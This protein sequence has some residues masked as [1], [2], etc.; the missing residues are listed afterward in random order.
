MRRLVL[1]GFGLL[2]A[3]LP[4][5][6]QPALNPNLSFSAPAVSPVQQ[7]IQ[8][9]YRTQ[10]LQQQ[11]ELLL[12]NP[13]GLS[14]EQMYIESPVRAVTEAQKTLHWRLDSD[15]ALPYSLLEEMRDEGYV[16]YVIAPFVYAEG[17]VNALSWATARPGGFSEEHLKFLDAVLPALSVTVELKALR[18]FIPHVLA[19]YV[20]E[21]P[22]RLILDGQ[23]RRGDV[24]T[25]T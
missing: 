18:R 13:S 8:E 20:G 24:T 1:L 25:I 14:R 21:E 16:H 4:A 22:G 19:T 5:A 6:A 12:Q 15:Q 17:L 7:Q 10:L 9:N 11:R 23:V 2:V 3:A